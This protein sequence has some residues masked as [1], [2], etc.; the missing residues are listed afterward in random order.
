MAESQAQIKTRIKNL[1]KE[2]AIAH[3]DI[4]RL[5]ALITKME[6]RKAKLE[7]SLKPEEI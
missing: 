6:A 4:D 3:K 2:L 5:N 1:T 7:A